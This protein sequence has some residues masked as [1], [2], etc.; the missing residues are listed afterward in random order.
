[1]NLLFIIN[2]SGIGA[3]EIDL[4]FFKDVG[5]IIEGD[6]RG[7]SDLVTDIM[8]DTCSKEFL[9]TI[10]PVAKAYAYKETYGMFT[11]VA[12]LLS[13]DVGVSCINMSVG[14]YNPHTFSEYVIV[15]DLFHATCFAQD[16]ITELG[17]ELYAHHTPK[18]KKNQYGY[19]EVDPYHLYDE[20]MADYDSYNASFGLDGR[21]DQLIDLDD[22]I[23][24]PYKMTNSGLMC[25]CGE[26]L[27]SR[28]YSYY[29]GFCCKHYIV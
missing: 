16:C 9:K 15:E 8:D 2:K 21:Q 17:N 18:K 29:C 12:E 1:M 14:Y 11:D 24:N 26:E 13:R 28:F 27:E 19:S 4:D 7:N 3:A 25:D 10:L 22:K 23:S 5:Y 6:R 20:Y